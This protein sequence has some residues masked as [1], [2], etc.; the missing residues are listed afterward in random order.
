M[1]RAP[2]IVTLILLVSCGQG[3]ERPAQSPSAASAASEVAR[4]G[5]SSTNTEG[6]P[7]PFFVGRWASEEANCREAPWVITAEELQTPGEVTCRFQRVKRTERGAD[8]EAAC[9][10]EGPPEQWTLRF[11]YAQSARALLIENAPFADIGLVRCEESAAESADDEVSAKGPR[12]AADVLRSYYELLAAGR[13]EDASLLWTPHERASA[14]QSSK[15]NLAQYERFD[16]EIGAPGR[17]EGAAGSLY[18]SV[19]VAVDAMRN[20]DEHVQLSGEAMLRRS[21]DVPGATQ[22]Q[23]SWGIVRIEL[24]PAGRRDSGIGRRESGI[25]DRSSPPQG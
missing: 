11:G 25:S 1:S 22:E 17:I 21:N 14:M 9:Y 16:V 10:A 19:P 7:T 2:L 3:S 18:I 15:E 8:V 24:Q 13:V 12:G 5:G 6:E 20:G 4:S 23:L